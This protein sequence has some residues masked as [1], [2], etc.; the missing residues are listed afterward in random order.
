MTRN[1]LSPSYKSPR[2]PPNSAS[3]RCLLAAGSSSALLSTDGTACSGTGLLAEELIKDKFSKANCCC[4]P[5]CGPSSRLTLTNLLPALMTVAL[6]PSNF[7]LFFV[8]E[9]RTASPG[10]KVWFGAFSWS[11]LSDLSGSS[12]L[13]SDFTESQNVRRQAT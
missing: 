1:S 6:K 12:P 7:F 11:F 10:W 9:R 8:T 2:S 13:G 3:A 5:L 4:A